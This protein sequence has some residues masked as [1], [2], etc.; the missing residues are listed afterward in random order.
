MT[1]DTADAVLFAFDPQH[2]LRV[3]TILRRWEPYPGRRALPGGHVDLGEPTQLAAV[4]ELAEET[5][6][7]VSVD[8]MTLVGIYGAPG[9]DPRGP[10]RTYAYAARLDTMPTPVAADDAAAAEWTPVAMIRADA[11]SMA[12]DH[13][14]IVLAAATTLALIRRTGGA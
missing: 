9:R 3:L 8:R 5:G 2:V 13:R 1:I 4:R 7:H 10:Y 12:F 14:E 11:D 6:V